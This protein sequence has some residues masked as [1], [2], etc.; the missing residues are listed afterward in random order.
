MIILPF[1]LFLHITSKTI[2]LLSPTYASDFTFHHSVTISWEHSVSSY[3]LKMFC[4]YKSKLFFQPETYLYSLVLF[5]KYEITQISL[6][7]SVLSSEV[8]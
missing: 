2:H 5:L 4:Y 6:L 1:H 8:L 7:D 3:C